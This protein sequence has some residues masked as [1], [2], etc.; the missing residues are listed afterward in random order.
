M[1]SSKKDTVGKEGSGPNSLSQ[2]HLEGCQNVFWVSPPQLPAEFWFI[3]LGWSARIYT[4]ASLLSSQLLGLALDLGPLHFPLPGMH[5]LLPGM[6]FPD[7]SRN[8]ASSFFRS[9]LKCHLLRSFLTI[10]FFFFSRGGWKEVLFI[11]K[12]VKLKNFNSLNAP[13]RSSLWPYSLKTATLPSCPPAASLSPIPSVLFFSG[14]LI[15]F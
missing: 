9:L 3:G 8:Q 6:Y 12:T 13:N 11:F 7:T 5:F 10:F 2:D 4:L 15:T 14:V 1:G